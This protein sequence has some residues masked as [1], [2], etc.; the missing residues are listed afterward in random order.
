MNFY[1]NRLLS[2]PLGP[3]FTPFENVLPEIKHLEQKELILSTEWL[4]IKAGYTSTQVGIGW[5]GAKIKKA[6]QTFGQER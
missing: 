4:E 2:V 3:D 6:S 1:I 5:A